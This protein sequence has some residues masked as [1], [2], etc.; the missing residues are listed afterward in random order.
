VDKDLV[1]GKALLGCRVPVIVASPFSRGNP[2]S[3]RINSL[4]YDHT[5]VLKFIEWRYNLPPLTKR[6]ASNEISNLVYA[7]DLNNPNPAVP[8]LPN[9]TAPP[10][11][12]CHGALVNGH[13]N[14]RTDSYDLLQA[15]ALQGW[16]V[17]VELP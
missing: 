8:S 5:S 14:G 13:A 1:K 9:V 15:A 4:L 6:D 12:G 16:P 3:P 10:P 2:N 7:L 11:K 17:S